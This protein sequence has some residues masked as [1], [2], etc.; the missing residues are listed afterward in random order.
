MAGEAVRL[1]WR[2][3]RR[4]AATVRLATLPPICAIALF[5]AEGENL[6]ATAVAVGVAAAW[7]VACAWRLR[8]SGQPIPVGVDV[9]VLVGVCLSVF[10]TEAVEDTNTGWLRLLL[11]FAC[12]TW[13]WH[14]P[15]V[16][17]GAAA[18]AAAGGM[19]AVLSA[20][21][22]DSVR[23]QVWMLVV[24]GLSRVAWVL[25][26]RAA[27]RADGM[28]VVAERARR[29]AAVAAA[30]RADERELATALH[31][32]AATTLLMVGV[33]RVP[34]G[35][36][37]LAGQ[38]RRDL[39]RLRSSGGPTPGRADL[40]ELLRADVDTAHLTVEFDVP[41]RLALPFPVA[42]AIADAAREA[43][44]NVRRHAGTGRATVRLRG[45]ATA[46]RLE[47]ADDGVGFAV[48]DVPS[49]RRGLRESVR[50]R[51]ER[52]GGTA[53]VDSAPGSGTVVCLRWQA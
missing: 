42:R 39:E 44:T 50:G 33:G 21:G 48:D 1:L 5:R 4:H 11:T 8:G 43:V 7:T 37:W 31:D 30:V 47:I 10:W 2:F 13:Q 15:L 16:A 46:L 36:G 41:E 18:L 17:G 34:S 38:A 26:A 49:T 24:A 52:I 27:R 9:A 51:L 35:A 53:T 45:D 3:G 25:V 29:E 32:T 40:V 22:L 6:S 23:T 28:A 19:L 12:V 20:A 14:T